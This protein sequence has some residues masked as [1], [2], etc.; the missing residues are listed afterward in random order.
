MAECFIE[1]FQEEIPARMQMRAA[2]DLRQSFAAKLEETG[3]E[4]GG[5]TSHVTPVRLVLHIE[6]LVL[7]QP[8]RHLETKGPLLSAPENAITGFLKKNGLDSVDQCVRLQ[9]PKGEALLYRR[10][11][12]GRAAA[13]LLPEILACV[14]CGF[15]WPKT[16][17]FADRDFRWV[18]PL[19]QVYLVLDQ[20][21]LGGELVLNNRVLP[22]ASA[23]VLGRD[24]YTRPVTFAAYQDA[25]AG[26][27]I[28]LSLRQREERIRACLIEKA[29][30]LGCCWIPDPGLLHEVAGLT[31]TPRVIFGIIEDRF[32]ALP[33]EVLRL[34]MKVHQKYFV[35]HQKEGKK[36]SPLFAIVVPDYVTQNAEIEAVV[37]AG[38]QRVLRSR[39]QDAEFFLRQDQ[40][41]TLQQHSENLK[42]L[43]FAEGLGSMQDK[44]ERIAALLRAEP[45]SLSASEAKNLAMLAKADL[46]TEMVGEFPELQGFVG[47]H[48]AKAEGASPE[49]QQA[50]AE[51]YAPKGPSDSVPETKLGAGLAM[52]DKLDT[53][54]GFV[55]KDALPKGSGD[56]FAIRRATL[57]VLR[58][59]ME[60]G[61][62]DLLPEL[63]AKALKGY[64]EGGNIDLFYKFSDFYRARMAQFLR[65]QGFDHHI[66][67]AAM[68]ASYDVIMETAQA[69]QQFIDT[70]ECTALKAAYTRVQGILKKAQI[71]EAEMSRFVF[72]HAL[73]GLESV[74]KDLWAAIEHFDRTGAFEPPLE[75]LQELGRLSEPLN[76]FFDTVFINAEDPS[77]RQTRLALVHAAANS[78]RTVADFDHLI[79]G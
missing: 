14:L 28:I 15:P 20:K 44:V 57:G 41:I 54:A 65:D 17:R 47:A 67:L 61:W 31:E 29:E 51:H 37:L 27:G 16:M 13:E 9:T 72:D 4:Y 56:P 63:A 32:M 50:I 24:D 66:A 53:I 79:S 1:I 35:L 73:E 2:E 7:L 36:L 43:R 70:P 42:D 34:A 55:V 39:L 71:D 10:T 46:V 21:V 78:F 45:L 49:S 62:L 40:R 12:P 19:R 76:H 75:A 26:K 33:D 23:I 59:M 3:L 18:R 6:G 11:I 60:R 64:G 38:N 48:Y 68:G 58:I 25:L 8:D 74:D 30:Q 52:M 69:L 77:I 5:I 22:L